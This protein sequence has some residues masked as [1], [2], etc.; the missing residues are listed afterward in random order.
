METEKIGKQT[1]KTNTKNKFKKS[2]PKKKG[3]NQPY[4]SNYQI[5]LTVTEELR[6]KKETV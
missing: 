3:T 5:T 1:V 4:K 2:K 6:E